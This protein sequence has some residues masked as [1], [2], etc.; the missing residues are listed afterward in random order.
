[1]CVELHS[2]IEASLAREEINHQ[3]MVPEEQKPPYC[4]LKPEPLLIKFDQLD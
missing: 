3:S 1:M 2:L 4:I